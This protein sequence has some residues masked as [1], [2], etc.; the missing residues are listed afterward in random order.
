[1]AFI[2]TLVDKD[3]NQILP[4][5]AARAVLMEDGMSAEEKLKSFIDSATALSIIDEQIKLAME[6][7]Y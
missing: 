6:E 4:R 7:A 2:K 1:M 5:T 3:D